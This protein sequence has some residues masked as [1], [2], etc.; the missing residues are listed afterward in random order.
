MTVF[1]ILEHLIDRMLKRMARPDFSET[2][3]EPMRLDRGMKEVPMLMPNSEEESWAENVKN[4]IWFFTKG[5]GR[6]DK[7]Y[8]RYLDKMMA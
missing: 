8:E 7:Q 3:S 1:S 6:A 2:D 4:M 5:P